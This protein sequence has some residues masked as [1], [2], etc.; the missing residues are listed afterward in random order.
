MSDKALVLENV[1]KRFGE[2]NA[3][4][5]ISLEVDHGEFV[6]FIG[7]SG[8]GKTTTLRLIAGLE[9]PTSGLIRIDGQL[10]NDMKPWERDTP[11]VWQNFALFPFLNVTKNVEFGLKMRKVEKE[12][13]Q[14]ARQARP[15]EG[16]YRRPR[17]SLDLAALGRPEAAGRTGAGAR[18]GSEGAAAGRAAGV[19]RRAFACADA[20]RAAAVAAG[21]RDHV[22]LRD[23]QPVGGARDGRSD[24]RHVPG[25][26]P[27]G[28]AAAGGVP[29]AAQPLRGRVRRHQQHPLRHRH[30]G[31]G[32][33]GSRSRRRPASS[34][35]TPRTACPRSG[36]RPRS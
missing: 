22:R 18:H 6:A 2:V 11:L 9:A 17:G 23:A 35:C 14:G 27:A 21:A 3:V 19:A 30:G 10:T 29:A 36:R 32:G 34:P 31:G 24:H 8:C 26:D 20:E 28:R 13:A 12:R 5:G 7:P 16:R 1:V 25:R 15:R 4:A 33:R